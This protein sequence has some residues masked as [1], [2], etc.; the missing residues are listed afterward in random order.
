MENLEK[1]IAVESGIK[2]TKCIKMQKV[3]KTAVDIT[4]YSV[5]AAVLLPLVVIGGS[6]GLVGKVTA[7]L[8]CYPFKLISKLY[9][10]IKPDNISYSHLENELEKEAY[11]C[12]NCN[13]P[14]E[15]DE[16]RASAGDA[17][18]AGYWCKK[19]GESIELYVQ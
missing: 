13:A 14:M 4:A 15:W 9:D 7:E 19:C 2:N 8:A 11:T 17:G 3:L 18:S 16:C 6:I 12:P 1:K 5:T 10:K